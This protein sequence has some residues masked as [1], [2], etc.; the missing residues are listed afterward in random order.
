MNEL[1][2]TWQSFLLKDTSRF[3]R[4]VTY[5]KR[6][7]CLEPTIGYTPLL[8]ATNI[9]GDKLLL[10]RELVFV[11]E[12]L[13][14][15]EQAL[16]LGDIVI[17]TSSGSVSAVGK[18][19]R[20]RTDWPGTIGAFCGIVR[21]G[22]QICTGY[23]ALLLQ[24]AAIREKWS[25][26]ARGTNIN[27]LKR[28]DIENVELLLP[29]LDEQR[30]IV[31]AIEALFTYLDA[32]VDSLRRAKRNLDRLRVAILQDAVKGRLAHRSTTRKRQTRS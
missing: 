29:P 18:S 12:E 30:R 14:K 7:A 4:G 17:A 22:P 26:T 32:A 25:K 6:Q 13:V 31:A 28:S 23:L 5:R 16:R 21:A 2:T 9:V 19:A 1:P 24:S 8:R 3:I 10:D 11:P 15:T 20:L 27:N